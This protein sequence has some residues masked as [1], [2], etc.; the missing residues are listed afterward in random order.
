MPYGHS[1][2]S[3][4]KVQAV[5]GGGASKNCFNMGRHCD[6]GSTASLSYLEQ[7]VMPAAPSTYHVCCSIRPPQI[8][9]PSI[10]HQSSI[11]HNN[12]TYLSSTDPQIIPLRQANM[13]TGRSGARQQNRNQSPHW[14]REQPLI[15]SNSPEASRRRI[16]RVSSTSWNTHSTCASIN[17][18]SQNG[19][20]RGEALLVIDR[21][22][23]ENLRSMKSLSIEYDQ[24][25]YKFYLT[26][27]VRF[28][29]WFFV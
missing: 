2:R 14:T 21:R 15:Q 4:G 26:T 19:H 27:A 29:V 11:N 5:A 10:C 9:N 7:I 22:N 20:H 18:E 23:R 16:Y 25:A 17:T 3:A 28:N 8:S 13:K 6:R 12:T 1:S 24:C